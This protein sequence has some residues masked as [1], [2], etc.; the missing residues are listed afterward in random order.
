MKRFLLAG[1]TTVA[2]STAAIPTVQAEPT[3]F[4]PYSTRRTATT[5]LIAPAALATLAQ[6]G[7]LRAQGI[8]GFQ[9]LTL[10]YTLGRISA[11][12]VING[13]IAARLLPASAANDAAYRDAVDNQLEILLNVH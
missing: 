7:E 6:Q 9:N 12:E 11:V 2:L 13:A 4:N 3:A 10:E 5:A 8:P 1:L